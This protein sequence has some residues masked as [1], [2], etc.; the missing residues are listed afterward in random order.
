VLGG[1]NAVDADGLREDGLRE[2]EPVASYSPNDGKT[3]VHRGT[4]LGDDD[5]GLLRDS[6]SGFLDGHGAAFG[7]LST[8]FDDA[9]HSN[10]VI[11]LAAA[12]AYASRY[13]PLGPGALV[14]GSEPFVSVAV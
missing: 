13:G 11:D 2:G 14:P 5:S 1:P 12:L 10:G 4:S 3:A 8:E 9:R 7:V 6:G